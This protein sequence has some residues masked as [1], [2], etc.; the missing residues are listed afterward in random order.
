MHENIVV[1]FISQ[2]SINITGRDVYNFGIYTGNSLVELQKQMF[3]QNLKPHH[4]YGFDS[5]IGLPA[6]APGIPVY[7]GHQKGYFNLIADDMTIDSIINAI[8]GRLSYPEITS[9]IPGF[10]SDTLNHIFADKQKLKPAIYI[11]IDCDLYISTLQALE[12]M[13]DRG[14]IIKNTI[15]YFDDWGGVEEFAGGESLAWREFQQ[16]YKYKNR[17]F[18]DFGNGKPHRQKAFRIV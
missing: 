9:I 11:E 5:F 10:F 2:N 12:F 15:I 6:E 4:F 18:F 3:A 13:H 7:K 14:L 1:D 17:V 8:K 16:R